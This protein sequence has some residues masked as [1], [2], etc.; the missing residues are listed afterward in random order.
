MKN[1]ISLI[2]LRLIII[3]IKNNFYLD[4]NHGEGTSDEINLIGVPMGKTFE[5]F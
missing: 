5:K 2:I 1:K 3:K 4:C